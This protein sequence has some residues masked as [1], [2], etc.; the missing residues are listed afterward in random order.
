MRVS[1]DETLKLDMIAGNV[2]V[3]GAAGVGVAAVVPVITKHTNATIDHDARVTGKGNGG[4]L[5]VKTGAYTVTATDTRF[6]GAGVSGNTIDT[7]IDLGFQTGDTVTY[8]N[9]R[10]HDDRRPRSEHASTT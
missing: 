5:T 9:G 2:A 8:D 7:G 1:A 6:N 4:G 10:R 3:G